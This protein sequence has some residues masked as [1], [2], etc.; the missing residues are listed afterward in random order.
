MSRN[1]I[2]TF[3]GFIR[4]AMHTEAKWPKEVQG[5]LASCHSILTN[6]KPGLQ[7]KWV[8]DQLVE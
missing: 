6:R 4:T 7:S 2:F 1:Y 8:I 5:Q 3:H